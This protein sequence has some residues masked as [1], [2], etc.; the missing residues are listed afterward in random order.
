M[1]RTLLVGLVVF[2]LT[3]P[4]RADSIDA[5]VFITI[6]QSNADGSAFFDPHI[7]SLMCQWYESPLNHRRIKIWYRS[8][9]VQNR[10]P[11]ARGEAARWAVDGDTVDVAPGWLDLWYRNENTAGR[12]AMNIIHSYG[13]YSTGSGVDCAQGRRGMEPAFGKAIATALPDMPLYILKL[14][15]SGSFI[16]SWANPLDDTN[17]RYFVDNIYRPAVAD[18]QSRGLC[19]RIVGVWWMQGCADARASRE[20]YQECLNRLVDRII[21]ELGAPADAPIFIGRIVKPGESTV[22]PAG[23]VAYSENVRRAQN[24]VAATHPNVVI[25]DTK[26]FPMQ[27]ETPFNGYIHFSH[28]GLTQL[29]TRLASL[30]LPHLLPTQ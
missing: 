23:S 28:L 22:T 27:Y 10:P 29:G 7:D 18:L 16:S 11:N 13:S 20:Y 8:V 14:G 19:P 25:V 1:L 12:T 24:A 26:D 5:P 15:V 17:W 30:L 21:A 9:K 6:G 4:S 2:S 3:A